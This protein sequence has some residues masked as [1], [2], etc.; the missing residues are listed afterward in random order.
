MFHDQFQ[1]DISQQGQADSRAKRASPFRDGEGIIE[2]SI[3]EPGTYIAYSFEM[4][5]GEPLH[6]GAWSNQRISIALTSFTEFDRWVLSE[7][8]YA[9]LRTLDRKDGCLPSRIRFQAKRRGYY[10]VV[11]MNLS[12]RQ[13]TVI[14]EA[15]SLT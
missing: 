11:V 4:K 8:P 7:A 10:Q 9:K 3:L 5:R 15:Q 12:A 6:F 14:T 2:V 1:H 13:A